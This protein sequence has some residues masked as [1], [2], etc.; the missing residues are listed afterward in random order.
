MPDANSMRDEL[1]RRV[2]QWEAADPHSRLEYESAEAFTR[3]WAELDAFLLDGGQLPDAWRQGQI[4]LRQHLGSELQSANAVLMAQNAEIGELRAALARAQAELDTALKR[5][6]LL[7]ADG[8]EQQ[9]MA[10]SLGEE[11][12]TIIRATGTGREWELVRHHDGPG[13]WTDEWV[14]RTG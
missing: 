8:H 12:G 6:V 14:P 3:A 13:G 10:D 1:S 2:R 11:A 9:A 7:V 5:K 4:S